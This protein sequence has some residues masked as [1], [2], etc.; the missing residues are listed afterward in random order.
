MRKNK[1]TYK[2]K[3]KIRNK[4][5][6]KTVKNQRQPFNEQEGG[7]NWK[8]V[9][10]AGF[11]ILNNIVANAKTCSEYTVNFQDHILGHGA[12][13][14]TTRDSASTGAQKR[15]RVDEAI[16]VAI[17][18]H[19]E[20]EG[21]FAPLVEACTAQT[22]GKREY[23]VTSELMKVPGNQIVDK[24]TKQVM[25]EWEESFKDFKKRVQLYESQYNVKLSDVIRFNA[26]G[27]IASV[28]TGNFM[29]DGPFGIIYVVDS[30][31]VEI[32]AKDYQ[33]FMDE[34]ERHVPEVDDSRG[35]PMNPKHTLP[36]QK[37]K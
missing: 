6:R 18:L 4:K 31:L 9:L 37:Y 21:L 11:S 7:F 12:F 8:S 25:P 35:Y 23:I 26:D 36:G 2:N 29:A 1:S 3:N 34:L 14:I 10:V 20:S 15:F 32:N 24:R 30:D 33:I 28:N 13:H 17:A 5:R 19:M 27:S 22:K 16:S